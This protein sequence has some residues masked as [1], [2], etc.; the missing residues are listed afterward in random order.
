MIISE[1]LWNLFDLL[2]LFAMVLLA[3]V[4]VLTGNRRRSIMLFITF[5]LL[6]ALVWA[7]LRAPDIALAEVAIGAGLSGALLMSTLRRNRQTQD[8]F[9]QRPVWLQWSVGLLVMLVGTGIAWSLLLVAG[10]QPAEWRLGS[11]VFAELDN[12]GVTNPVTAVLLNFRA[13]DT[14]LELAVLLAAILGIKALGK[15]E[16]AYVRERAFGEL[17][18]WLT[19]LLVLMA[20]YILWAGAHAPGGAFQAGALLAAAG[21]VLRLAGQPAGGLPRNETG[22]RVGLVA[23][24]AIF[25]LVGIGVMLAGNSLLEYPPAQAKWWILVIETAATLSIGM[26]LTLAFVGGSPR[27]A[28]EPT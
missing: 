8:D 20:G 16:P 18:L 5:G 27:T 25:L 21:I 3:L 26:T 11:E 24:T 19:P 12:S 7:R 1:A 9:Q 4:A 28:K 17:A 10:A 23:G 22:L 14:L 2:L 15:S 6:L 13:W